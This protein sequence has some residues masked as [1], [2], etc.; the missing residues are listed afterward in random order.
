MNLWRRAGLSLLLMT[1]ALAFVLWHKLLPVP[2]FAMAALY[3]AAFYFTTVK[4]VGYRWAPVIIAIL[5]VPMGCFV[6][7]TH[8]ALAFWGADALALVGAGGIALT[9]FRYEQPAP[10][11]NR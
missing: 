5:A 6:Y 1:A 8:N 2:L 10:I 7:A 4:K 3:V 9:T 11:V